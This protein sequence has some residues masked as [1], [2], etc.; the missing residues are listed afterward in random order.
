MTVA[1]VS[2][3]AAVATAASGTTI[4]VN[5]P[6][7]TIA[8][9]DLLLMF[10]GQKPN[11]A[12][13]GSCTTPTGWTPI[14]RMMGGG[15]YGTTLA[16]DT[17]NT[18]LYCFAKE[19]VGGETGTLTVTVDGGA[20][21]VA[22]GVMSRYTKTA[23]RWSLSACIG[24]DISATGNTS[25]TMNQNPGITVGDMLASAMVIPTDV[26]TSAMFTAEAITATGLTTPGTTSEI[27][28]ASSANGNDIGGFLARTGPVTAGTATAA[29][30]LAA[31]V[32]NV[33]DARGPGM[34][35]RIREV[36]TTNT[37]IP[38]PLNWTEIQAA[39]A[40]ANSVVKPFGTKSGDMLVCMQGFDNDGDP[41]TLVTPSGWTL[42]GYYDNGANVY[43]QGAVFYKVAGGAEPDT[44]TFTGLTGSQDNFIIMNVANATM[45]SSIAYDNNTAATTTVTVPGQ[46]TTM[47][48][49]VIVGF[50]NLIPNFIS[51]TRIPQAS[52]T[53]MGDRGNITTDFSQSVAAWELIATS[54]TVTG[55]RSVTTS[56]A[57]SSA[58]RSFGASFLVSAAIV[59]TADST[60]A[61]TVSGA[62][63]VT[64]VNAGNSTPVLTWAGAS[65]AT[66]TKLAAASSA[67]SWGT[68]AAATSGPPTAKMFTAK[69]AFTTEDTVVWDGY[70]LG[71]AAVDVGRLRLIPDTLYSNVF[72]RAAK[73]LNASQ[74][75]IHL[76]QAPP[77]G[78]G[79]IQAFFKL[80][81]DGSGNNRLQWIIGNNQIQVD[82]TAAGVSSTPFTA[83]Y[84]ASTYAY[85]RIR[86]AG[87]SIYWDSSVDGLIWTNR[88][89]W[90]KTIDVSLMFVILQAGYYGTEPTPGTVYIDDLNL[91]VTARIS[92][93][94]TGSLK[95]NG[96]TW[97]FSGANAY[98]LALNDNT[99]S[100]G[101][102]TYPSQ[103]IINESFSRLYA[104]GFRLARIH[105]IG[106]SVGQPKTIMPTI[107]GS[108][109][110]TALDQ[111]DRVI[112]AARDAGMYLMVPLT[113]RWNFYHGGARAFLAFRGYPSSSGDS[114]SPF[115]SD[116]NIRSDY[117]A[118]ITALLNHVNPYTGLRWGDDP[119]IAIW[120]TGNEIYDAPTTW[121]SDIAAHIRSLAPLALIADGTAASGMH[122]SASAITDTNIDVM[123]GHFYDT[124]R[125]DSSWMA[126][127]AA[128]SAT[129]GKVYIIG[130]FAWN[131]ASNNGST[132]P[133]GQPPPYRATWLSNIR[134]NSAVS[135]DIFWTYVHPSAGT[136]RDGYEL[137]Y[138]PTENAEQTAG[139]TDLTGHAALVNASLG[140]TN[141]DSASVLS[142]AGTASAARIQMAASTASL[143]WAG[144]AAAS[145][146]LQAASA[147]G[148]SWNSTAAAVRS[149]QADSS[150][151]L[152]ITATASATEIVQ[153]AGVL[154]QIWSATAS[155]SVTRSAAA[156]QNLAFGNTASAGTSS[157][158]N[159]DS[160]FSLTVAGTAAAD[161]V[162]NADGSSALSWASIA[163]ASIARQAASTSA[164]SWSGSAA[165]ARIQNA[166]ASFALTVA[167][168]GAVA[169]TRNADSSAPLVIAGTGTASEILQASATQNL[170]VGMIADPAGST[171]ANSSFSLAIA[172]SADSARTAAASGNS[173]LIVGS[174]ASASITRAIV[175]ASPL[176]WF[177]TASATRQSD[178][179]AVAGLT[180][181]GSAA[182]SAVRMALSAAEIGVTGSA[183]G[184]VTRFGASTGSLVLSATASASVVRVAVA[185]SVLTVTG[186][187]DL[188]GGQTANSS[189]ELVFGATTSASVT[190]FGSATSALAIGGTGGASL[191]RNVG[192]AFGLAISSA[193]DATPVRSASAS[194]TLVVTGAANAVATPIKST[195]AATALAWSTVA[196]ASVTRQAAAAFVLNIS[197]SVTPQRQVNGTAA[198]L[199]LLLGTGNGGVS[200]IGDAFTTKVA[201]RL[202]SLVYRAGLTLPPS[203]GSAGLKLPK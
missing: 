80:D 133:G 15:G 123:G 55:T 53:A 66:Q 46:T 63:A 83:T 129:N 191:V 13:T 23:T 81:V 157:V 110:A 5:Y 70:G 117:K 187:S 98:W 112:A 17:G 175:A 170:V 199:L 168:T 186:T 78:N 148:L 190:R 203:P 30:V 38:Y 111:A 139:W 27:T 92:K 193:S 127:D 145:R 52:M 102:P 3:G 59:K 176:T 67:L 108:L 126:T 122:V 174:T 75:S 25:I 179:L 79:T 105:S 184:E 20:N 21:A 118:Y 115:W 71:R 65:A 51:M 195:D 41:T 113:D 138:T 155:A 165:A 22:W 180:L 14:A 1:Y 45:V 166:D 48:N 12:N 164:L 6:A 64:K 202:P 11:T 76:I 140:I 36:T 200:T 196:Q 8:A 142:W 86:E 163:S 116:T 182:V 73:D 156:S 136:H 162:R 100:S 161:R 40:G 97:R 95:K 37:A 10:V 189:A 194:A 90:V 72:M 178:G 153:G 167:G 96:L 159:V 160:T 154:V 29:P 68:T 88:W 150:A 131:D 34:I 7:A 33:T 2:S 39:P 183:A 57:V 149:T 143:S 128:A 146:I 169:R 109:D 28:E 61:L 4:A 103:T 77:A 201:L 101:Q 137:Y 121:T 56:A 44:Y 31:T 132:M 158:A 181:T 185:V 171:Q 198:F 35:V 134:S 93:N 26:S 85:L 69:D 119:T 74:A 50:W 104:G 58:A 54:G 151:N 42:L 172:A 49:Q 192:S 60:Q 89:T 82:Y 173:A 43:A 106:I 9:G 144:S 135:G 177:G 114:L 94:S 152:A 141:A 16:A 107:N 99:L 125:M 91:P 197:R 120:E 188:V 147:L 19:A 87:G 124:N 130:E 62:A 18:N 84:N 32:A 47:A 24:Q